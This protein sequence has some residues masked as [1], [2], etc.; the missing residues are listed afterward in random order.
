[1]YEGKEELRKRNGKITYVQ[2]KLMGEEHGR[3]DGRSTHGIEDSS[4]RGRNCDRADK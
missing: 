4:E 1:M 2:M 3:R